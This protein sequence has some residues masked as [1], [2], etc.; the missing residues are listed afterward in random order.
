MLPTHRTCPA[1]AAE[2]AEAYCLKRLSAEAARRFEWHFLSC[3][4][5]SVAV[6][7]ALDFIEAMRLS[8]ERQAGH[9]PRKY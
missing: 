7:Q 2:A 9:R 5:C 1:D 3:P 4:D 8:V 6:E